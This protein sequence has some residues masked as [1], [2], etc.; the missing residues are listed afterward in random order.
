MK[1]WDLSNYIR[2][3]KLSYSKT[4]ILND[5]LIDKATANILISYYSDALIKIAIQYNINITEISQAEEWY[6]LRVYKVYL[7]RYLDNPEGLKLAKEE[8]EAT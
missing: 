5:L 2:L 8:I 7:A 1:K 4:G 6:K 3:I